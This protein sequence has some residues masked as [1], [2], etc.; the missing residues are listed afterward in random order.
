MK[1][2]G[3]LVV[4]GLVLGGVAWAAESVPAGVDQVDEQAGEFTA[5]ALAFESRVQVSAGCNEVFRSLTEFQRLQALV[6]HLQG[7]SAVTT[8][9]KPGDS[10]NYEFE[11]AD[12]TKNKGRLVLT[13]IEPGNRVQVLVQPDEGPWQR[14]QEFRLYAPAAGP[15]QDKECNVS[16]EETYNPKVLRN[17]AYNMK[18]IVQ[19][20]RKPYME[21]ILRRLKNLAEGNEPG[22]KAEVTKLK[23]IARNFP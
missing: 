12:G 14:V 17:L 1:T 9:T 21:I 16:Y 20:V 2:A 8:G 11:R 23:E 15:K 3:C 4:I 22:P 13:T 5:D 6:P 18:E 10:L 19:E 7:K